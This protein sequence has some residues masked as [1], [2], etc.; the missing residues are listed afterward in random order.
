MFGLQN[1]LIVLLNLQRRYC[2]CQ[3]LTECFLKFFRWY[4]LSN[5]QMMTLLFR[6]FQAGVWLF[7]NR[8]CF[9]QICYL[10][11]EE[12]IKGGGGGS[13]KID[14]SLLKI[15]SFTGIF[16]VFWPQVQNTYFVEHLLVV[17]SINYIGNYVYVH[18]LIFFV[19]AQLKVIMLSYVNNY[20][21]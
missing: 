17:A 16:Q 12:A 4:V 11:S 21:L 9:Y 20:K 7:Y 3:S 6:K 2:I 10:N 1:S 8:F 13:T 14:A 19:F 18:F 15:N 5:D